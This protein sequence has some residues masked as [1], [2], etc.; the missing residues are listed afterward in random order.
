MTTPRR[1]LGLGPSPVQAPASSTPD[2][3]TAARIR[4]AE[5]DL[6]EHL[7]YQPDIAVDVLRAQGVLGGRP[8]STEAPAPRSRAY[9]RGPQTDSA[10]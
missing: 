2:P 8:A 9:G 5:A 1:R 6:S 10:R 3:G 4:A 7:L